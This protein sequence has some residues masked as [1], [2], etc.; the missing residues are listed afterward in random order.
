MPGFDIDPARVRAALGIARPSLP[1]SA[2]WLSNVMNGARAPRRGPGSEP[3]PGDLRRAVDIACDSADADEHARAVMAVTVYA[4][5]HPEMLASD[6]DDCATFRRLDPVDR[7]AVLGN[8]LTLHWSLKHPGRATWT[9]ADVWS[10]LA[11]WRIDAER[12]RGWMPA[13]PRAIVDGLAYEHAE[14]HR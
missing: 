11:D 13:L 1:G 10:I 12:M 6:G 3:A 9:H 2:D 14:M 5:D 8:L 7:R 4:V